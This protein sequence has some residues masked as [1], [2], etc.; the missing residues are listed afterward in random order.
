MGNYSIKTDR[1]PTNQVATAQSMN[2][3]ASTFLVL[4]WNLALILRE[5]LNA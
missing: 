5:S 2:F 3:I 1:E 4:P